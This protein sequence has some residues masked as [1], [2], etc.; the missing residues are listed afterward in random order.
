[1]LQKHVV[2]GDAANYVSM[3]D[4]VIVDWLVGDGKKMFGQIFIR[5]RGY[6]AFAEGVFYGLVF[7]FHELT[8]NVQGNG[9][10]GSGR[11]PL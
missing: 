7:V 6:C 5:C 4:A 11:S 8:P 2:N 1:M 3:L 9:L 10:A